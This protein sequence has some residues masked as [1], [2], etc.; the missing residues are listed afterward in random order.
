MTFQA[1]ANLSLQGLEELGVYFHSG[2]LPV[3]NVDS[4]IEKIY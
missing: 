4:N 1:Y 3:L 2:L